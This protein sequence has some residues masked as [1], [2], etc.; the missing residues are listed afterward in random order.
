MRLS[1]LNMMSFYQSVAA[2][3]LIAENTAYTNEESID[4]FTLTQEIN[5]T[6]DYRRVD[7]SFTGYRDGVCDKTEILL[8]VFILHL[9]IT[10]IYCTYMY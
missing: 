2:L 3:I 8:N 9:V 1:V 7:L 6:V 10:N 4:V 5:H